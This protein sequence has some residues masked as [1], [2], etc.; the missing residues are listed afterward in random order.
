MLTNN[1]EKKI[2]NKNQNQNKNKNNFYI[3]THLKKNE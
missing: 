2:K 3:K 1:E